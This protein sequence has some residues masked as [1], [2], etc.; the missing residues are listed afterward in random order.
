[1]AN[2][3]WRVPVTPEMHPLQAE[4]SGHQ[5]LGTRSNTKESGII[6]YSQGKFPAVGKTGHLTA[7]GGDELSFGSRQGSNNIRLGNQV[8]VS[9][10]NP[11]HL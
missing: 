4:I 10:Y 5:Q 3:L 7:N 6:P 11:R 9:R 1:M 2:T 8:S